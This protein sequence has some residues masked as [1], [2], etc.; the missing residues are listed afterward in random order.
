MRKS[1]NVFMTLARYFFRRFF[2]NDLLEGS[3]DTVT[4]VVRALSIVAVPGLM[5]A[6]F[7]QNEYPRRSPWGRIEDHY[8]FVL[9]SF[10]A[11][12][13]VAIFEW[14]MLFPDRLDF[15][16]LSPLPLRRRDLLGA[17]AGALIS[18]LALFVFA[19][20]VLGWWML[21][22]VSKERFWLHLWAHGVAVVSAGAFGASA[23]LAAGGL[24]ICVLPARAFRVISPLLQMLAVAVLG[25]L[26]VHYV[27][28]GDV[29][30]RTLSGQL[31]TTRFVPTFWFLGVYETLLRGDSAAAFARPMAHL[32]SLP[33]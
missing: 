19:A 16:V 6:F 30:D 27:R 33:C 22:V 9:Y 12:A 8:F 29:L 21:P 17:K 32:A 18:F 24:L 31:G 26:L 7:L 10:L 20:D 15:L 13:G 14:E 28:F 23:V 4:T 2:E 25:L 11:M 3:G 5:L 1:S